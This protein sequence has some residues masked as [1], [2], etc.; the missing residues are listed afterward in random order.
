LSWGHNPP[1]PLRLLPRSHSFIHHQNEGPNGRKWHTATQLKNKIILIGG[2]ATNKQFM[3]DVLVLD[4]GELA[5]VCLCLLFVF[6]V[7][8]VRS[9]QRLLLP[10]SFP[11]L[12]CWLAFVCA[13]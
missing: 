5:V 2:E 12:L 10:S 8:G 6:V 9:F 11:P 3:R 13:F 1:N 7:E 4:L